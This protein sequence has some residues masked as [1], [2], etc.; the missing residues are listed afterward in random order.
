MNTS[1]KKV[2][3]IKGLDISINKKDILNDLNFDLYEGEF[4]Y[5]VGDS[6]SGKSSF[7][8]TTFL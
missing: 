7:L 5:I 8:K 6:G 4:C 2:V 1:Y 3:F